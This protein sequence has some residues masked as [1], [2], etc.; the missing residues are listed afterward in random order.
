LVINSTLWSK[1][2]GSSSSSSAF[3]DGL[4]G[5]LRSAVLNSAV[6]GRGGGSID[7]GGG[8]GG[9]C[10]GAVVLG[11]G[12]LTIGGDGGSGG[13]ITG[14]AALTTGERIGG[15]SGFCGGGT[16][17]RGGGGAEVMVATGCWG[18]FGGAT[19]GV[20]GIRPDLTYKEFFSTSP[21][22][23]ARL[24]ITFWNLIEYLEIS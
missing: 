10:G 9:G 4:Y 24:W 21:H 20:G 11:R 2:T 19:S 12:G 15:G 14:G 8:G 18:I 22:M 16:I 5:L 6:G 7:A 23:L 17:G 1:S 3:S 13:F